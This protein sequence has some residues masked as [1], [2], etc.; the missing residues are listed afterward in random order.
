MTDNK[1]RRVRVIDGSYV[2]EV[3]QDDPNGT[4]MLVPVKVWEMVMDSLLKI[5]SIE[6]RRSPHLGMVRESGIEKECIV[7]IAELAL[8]AFAEIGGGDE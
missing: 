5:S 8:R 6:R 2:G 7:C 4:H 1:A 3:I